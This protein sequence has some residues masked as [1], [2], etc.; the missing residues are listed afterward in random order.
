[1]R[2]GGTDKWP[3]WEIYPASDWNYGLTLDGRNTAASFEV[4]KKSWPASGQPFEAE[5]VPI[6]L[7]TKAKKIPQWQ[8]NYQG[9]I[10]EIQESPAASNEPVE[11]VTLIPMGAARLRISA[12]PTVSSGFDAEKWQAPQQASIPLPTKAS[13]CYADDTTD[14]LSDNLLPKNSIDHG[15]PRFTFW[16]HRGTN[17]WVEYDFE[18]PRKFEIVEVYW[19]DDTG[20]GRC[21]IPESW[22]V[23]YND[24]GQW[25]EVAYLDNFQPVPCPVE[26]DKFNE[27]RFLPVMTQSIRL[28]IQLQPNFSAGIL[29]WR[30]K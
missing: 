26:K 29:E 21:R 25:K 5:S 30:V 2:Q 19:F 24:N 12:F 23:L 3:A 1:M 17:E 4:I 15:I 6:E 9:L 10:E 14:A 7:K 8:L 20:I 18:K 11:T 13:H 22:K 16:D 28:E 27:S